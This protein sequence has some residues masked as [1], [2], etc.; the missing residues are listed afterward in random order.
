MDTFRAKSHRQSRIPGFIIK[1]IWLLV[2]LAIISGLFFLNQHFLKVTTIDCSAN[3]GSCPEAIL[4][5]AEEYKGHSILL[6][7]QRQL[8]REITAT[9]LADQAKISVKLPGQ[10]IIKIT[11]PATSYYVKSVFGVSLPDLTFEEST[12]SA[13][14]IAPS[15][16]L[17]QFTATSI[18]KTFRLLPS[19]VL[20]QSESETNYYLIATEIPSQD[21]LLS[22]FS[23]LKAITE[24]KLEPEA[25]YILPQMIVV[26]YQ[27]QPDYLFGLSSDPTSTLMALQRLLVAVTISELS[28]ID[29]RYSNP[30]LK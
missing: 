8:V 19:G 28:V 23:W 1:V 10:L 13:E 27:G 3:N 18:G 20:D 15:T 24:A 6:L 12:I 14:V 29:F 4:N 22:V 11:P 16:E 7:R 26:K 17:S 5:L 30:I 9:G 25:I 2:C 21:Y